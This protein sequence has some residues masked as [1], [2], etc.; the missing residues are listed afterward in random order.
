M[1]K[2]ISGYEYF[3]SAQLYGGKLTSL[4]CCAQG[5]DR[6]D[7]PLACLAFEQPPAELWQAHRVFERQPFVV[8]RLIGR[9]WNTA[10]RARDAGISL[11]RVVY[12]VFL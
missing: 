1:L 3:V 6:Q 12:P 11:I 8:S 4:D 7:A 2:N 5:I 9:F 10:H